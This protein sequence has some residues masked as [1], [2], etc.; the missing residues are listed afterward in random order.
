MREPRVRVTVITFRRPRL[1]ERAIGSLRA[2]T[3]PYWEAEVVNDAPD[4]P[5]P[6][7][8]VEAAGDAR[9]RMVA[10]ACRRGATENFNF[11]FRPGVIPYASVLEDDNWWEPDFLAEMVAAMDANP[12]VALMTANERIWEERENGEW[13][14]TNRTL[15]PERDAFWACPLSPDRTCGNA[16]VANSALLFRPTA[17][18]SWRVPATIPVDVTEHYR[19]RLTP[20]PFLVHDRVLVNFAVTRATGRSAEPR[21]WTAQQILLVGSVFAALPVADR[22][23]LASRL[24]ARLGGEARSGRTAFLLAGRFI[25]DAVDL[26]RMAM[27]T[28]QA[29]TVAFLFK[30]PSDAL[31]Y[32]ALQR[33]HA[34]EWAFLRQGAVADALA[35]GAFTIPDESSS[36][37]PL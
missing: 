17:I 19:E 9:I 3:F 13:V 11:A 7:A 14:R 27:P 20:H 22:R 1:L 5:D 10:P 12:T 2:Q 37:Q 25:P 33:T 35:A 32:R 18:P 34:E 28:D 21:V 24:I 26:W 29:W 6:A 31:Y 23:A 8:V 15:R 30:H 36:T 4:D 16:L